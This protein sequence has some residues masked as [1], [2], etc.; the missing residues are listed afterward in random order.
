M[1]AKGRLNANL[2][3]PLHCFLSLSV[4]VGEFHID[5]EGRVPGDGLSMT[6]DITFDLPH[7]QLYASAMDYE[8]TEKPFRQQ[9]TAVLAPSTPRVAGDV[10][11]R[12]P[13]VSNRSVPQ[14]L[15]YEVQADQHTLPTDGHVHHENENLPPDPHLFSNAAE[16]VA[17][18]VVDTTPR[19]PCT[20]ETQDIPT[21][22]GLSPS[23]T[24]E[25][26]P[27]EE[28]LTKNYGQDVDSIADKKLDP[29]PPPCVQ[30]REP[31]TADSFE[32]GSTLQ[33]PASEPVPP[34]V[35]QFRRL[36]VERFKVATLDIKESMLVSG[37]KGTVP[38]L[39]VK[40]A[41][42]SLPALR[43]EFHRPSFSSTADVAC[44]TTLCY[45][46]RDGITR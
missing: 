20:T 35:S 25:E 5:S 26:S 39:H 30:P 32:L 1:L 11:S 18:E 6:G 43:T 10:T 7:D 45:Q 17:C 4:L 34:G 28:L 9:K 23:G 22:T 31:C 27:A 46:R 13:A 8:E 19:Q 3:L 37:I 15:G 42:L 36:T 24:S 41:S 33:G 21:G 16:S 2:T 38:N 44:R 12:R 40:V 14:Q 29:E